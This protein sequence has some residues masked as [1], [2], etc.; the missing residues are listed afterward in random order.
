MVRVPFATPVLVGVKVT[1]TVQLALGTS[2]LV[3][4]GQVL[5]CVKTPLVPIV[6]MTRS[7]DP[8]FCN[9]TF[10]GE[11]FWPTFTSPK[12]SEVG[13]AVPTAIRLATSRM[14]LLPTSAI[15]RFAWLSTARP[16]LSMRALMAG[17][18]SQQ[19]AY[20][21]YCVSLPATVTTMLGGATSMRCTRSSFPPPT[22]RLPRESTASSVGFQRVALNA[23][24]PS[25]WN[26]SR[27]L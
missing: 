20:H 5:V 7:F 18:P 17:L 9:V 6:E 1:E 10:M 3:L 22:N 21:Q 23:G 15:S 2:E 27:P 24:P 8:V 13:V 16:A 11:L 14:R 12:L 25:P 4:E 26:T 19:Y